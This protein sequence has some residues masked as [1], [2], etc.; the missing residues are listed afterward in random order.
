MTRKILSAFLALLLCLS[1]AIS[2]SAE[3]KTID[4]VM[5]EFGYLAPEELN[6]LNKLAS[7]IYEKTGV[8]IFFVFTREESLS[9]YDIDGLI[10]GM[11]DY[12]IMLE[13]DTS[14]YT[15]CGG[16]G[17][18]IDYAAEDELRAVYDAA[19][20]YVGGVEDFLYAAAE[21]FPPITDTTGNVLPEAE[22]YLLFDEADL[23]SDSEELVLMQKLTNVSHSYNA[24]LVV[25]TVGSMKDS[26]I[27]S[28]VNYLYD[29]MGFGYGVNHDG[30][31]LLVCM[32]PR[33][34]RIL[35]NGFAGV[36]IDTDDISKICEEIVGN[37]SAGDYAGAFSE[38]ADECAYYLDGYINGFPFD[39]TGSLAVSL[40]IGLAVGAIVAFVLKGQLKTVRKQ[41]RAN[42]YVKSGSMH[43]D[44]MNDIFLYRNVT[45]TE[46]PKN[47]SSGSS[48]GTARSQGGGSF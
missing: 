17:E 47:D 35:S 11:E 9:D 30:V 23:L 22:E 8:G 24:Q 36:A 33:E 3:S 28:Y 27:D 46:K 32:D 25:A 31:L 10:N 20:T 21:Y 12:F 37:L 44:V 2:A 18:T 48:G 34:Y 13:N 40:I 14:W 26:D 29:T 41:N 19:D 4:F 16:L 15:F 5:D 45:R 42:V 38:F 39:T 6:K 1:M 7:D 43:I